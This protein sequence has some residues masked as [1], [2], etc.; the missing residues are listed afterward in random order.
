M[1]QKTRNVIILLY[2]ETDLFLKTLW[3]TGR[4]FFM[5]CMGVLERN[6][7]NPTGGSLSHIYH[8]LHKPSFLFKVLNYLSSANKINLNKVLVIQLINKDVSSAGLHLLLIFVSQLLIDTRSG[9]VPR[10]LV[11]RNNLNSPQKHIQRRKKRFFI[12]KSTLTNV[13][14]FYDLHFRMC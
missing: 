14:L 8:D 9:S 5:V 2:L 13:F 6:T 3:G 1:G 7:R 4:S 10:Q 11:L 12:L